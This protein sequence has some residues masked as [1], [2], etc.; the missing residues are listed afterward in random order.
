MV[1]VL[2]PHALLRWFRALDYSLRQGVQSIREL[3]RRL[4]AVANIP[5]MLFVPRTP[6]LAADADR[7]KNLT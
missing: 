3:E 6:S 2:Q 7:C 4:R 5:L 1:S